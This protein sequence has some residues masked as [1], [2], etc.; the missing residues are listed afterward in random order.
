MSPELYKRWRL[1]LGF[2]TAKNLA[3]HLDMAAISI[4]TYESRG[5]G[6]SADDKLLRI[7]EKKIIER[8][9][10]FINAVVET[11]AKFGMLSGSYTGTQ[12]PGEQTGNEEKVLEQ[13]ANTRTMLADKALELKVYDL[14]ER[15]KTLERIIAKNT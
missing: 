15:V 10:D 7:L 8:S 13:A 14:E 4:S 9:D 6:S 5:S 2:V 1:G 12:V 3:E 11:A